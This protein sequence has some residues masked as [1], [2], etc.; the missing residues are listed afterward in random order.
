MKAY[1]P[2]KDPRHIAHL[3]A[4][5]A[6]AK[7]DEKLGE[8]ATLTSQ[9]S[10]F[11]KFVT[12]TAQS[13]ALEAVT[14][15]MLAKDALF[16]AIG[17]HQA[18]GD[19]YRGVAF[20]QSIIEQERLLEATK[21][22]T[23]LSTPGDALRIASLMPDL[24]A[25]DAISGRLAAGPA[26]T[27]LVSESIAVQ[28]EQLAKIRLKEAAGFLSVQAGSQLAAELAGATGHLWETE[29]ARS[30]AT[31]AVV[32]SAF[33]KQDIQDRLASTN[34]DNYRALF[35]ELNAS[36]DQAKALNVVLQNTLY[37][38]AFSED[39]DL[40]VLAA[41]EGRNEESVDT[42]PVAKIKHG[43][44]E[45][46]ER[47]LPEQKVIRDCM[48]SAVQQLTLASAL[49]EAIDE[50]N[51]VEIQAIL[52]Q[53]SFSPNTL[54]Q[55]VDLVRMDKHAQVEVRSE[56]AVLQA[57]AAELKEDNVRM[58]RALEQYAKKRSDQTLIARNARKAGAAR[59][60]IA[61]WFSAQVA[62]GRNAMDP[63]LIK[64]GAKQF[65][66]SEAHIREIQKT[67]LAGKS[68]TSD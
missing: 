68:A 65:K 24:A 1:D 25:I 43:A 52:Q 42:A 27:A 32:G 13:K 16:K 31:A 17:S 46:A 5:G 30:R 55:M 60:K 15:A 59:P 49:L 47:S 38:A 40:A 2:L 20:A 4:L 6:R 61:A 12:A 58:Q 39:A 26:A 41:E 64:E 14:P 67:H 53:P 44:A 21:R 29:A 28:A 37:T 18:L 45:V 36:A 57:K 8:L 62:S 9:H 48:E 10:E 11:E 35:H 63:T 19:S 33:G 23:G 66:K 22:M 7:R 34:L 54:I 56:T 51:L 50:N 3:D